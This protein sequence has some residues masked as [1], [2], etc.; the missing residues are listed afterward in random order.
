MKL[1][2]KEK[3]L[4]MNA[5][6]DSIVRVIT[7]CSYI[8]FITVAFLLFFSDVT[9][10][11]FISILLFLF[12]IDRVIH[13]KK[14]ERSIYELHG[15]EINVAK[16]F[17]PNTLRIFSYSF[18]KSIG[19]ERDFY[20]LTLLELLKR[21]EIKNILGRLDVSHKE[22]LDKVIEYT[23][24]K[25]EYVKKDELLVLCENVAVEAYKNASEIGCEFVEPYNLFAAILS[26][27]HKYISKLTNLFE[28]VPDDV[29]NAIIYARYAKKYNWFNKPPSVIGGFAY[30]TNIVRSRFMN[31][32]WTA[33]PTPMLDQ[34][35]IDLTYLAKSKKTGFLI[36]HENE[37]EL[38]INAVSRPGKPNAIL[39]GEPGS[40]KSTIISNLAFR[41]IKDKVPKVLF[42]KRLVSLNVGALL[43]NANQG[44]LTQRIQKIANDISVAGNIVLFIPIVHD[45]FKKPIDGSLAPID[46]L[47]PIIKN[48]EIPVVCETYPREFKQF[49]EQRS[50]FTEQFD[51]INV[52]EI[53]EMN[54]IKL[55]IYE[56]IILEREF[57]VF[58][59]FGAI[60]KSV[61]LAHKYFRS[62]LLPG[63]ALD[64]LKQVSAYANENKIKTVSDDIV[65]EIAE[66]Q[67]K[68]PIQKAGEN[69]VNKLLNL[70]DIIHK[71]F[72]NQKEAVSSVANAIREF[73]SGLSRSGG[74]I[75]TFLF[76]GPTGVGKTELA[77]VLAETQFGSRDLMLR[78]DMSEYQ[79]KQSVSR[80]IGS[81]DGVRGGVLTDAILK[82][83]Y[84]LILLDEFEKANSE[85][86]NLFLQ[87]F[88]DGRLTDSLNRTVD[89]QN[90]II[91]AT[92][93]AHSDFIKN[94]IEK[95]VLF[96]EIVDIIKKKL[97][98]YFKPELINRFSSVVVFRNLNEDEICAVA[99]LMLL[100]VSGV[101]KN[102]HGITV[103]FSEGAIEKIA[104]LGYS[105]VFGARPLR[106][107]ISEK[108]RS[109]FAEMIL[110]KEI[111][112]G[113]TIN[114]IFEN[115]EFKFNIVD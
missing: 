41:M 28:I 52:S 12:L 51:V 98:D 97:T 18:R 9:K 82:N 16:A 25:S 4:Y 64:L 1:L 91:I 57:N 14:G 49:I 102:T 2:F 81:V 47:L 101:L 77:K 108:V 35:G 111:A 58:I 30:K 44:D 24:T 45:L 60:K 11:K 88:D 79:D 33:R 19:T 93:N 8:F 80:L 48:N 46:L 86:L 7:Y 104:K 21:K 115:G 53:K 72:I 39:V 95:G 87:V 69:E 106:Q 13:I 78:L 54:A 110:K 34:Y 32:A 73:R 22:F 62:K 59:T 5:F 26:T 76:V 114:F 10:L 67:S 89:F 50:D 90:T 17:S 6:S 99:K 113:N 68:I 42:D 112:R 65:V 71:K 43:S 36:G 29:S 40:G 85:I 92:S 38:L 103:N 31:R 105:P 84:S 15:D 37:M 3:R 75:A 20:F 23:N 61:L 70:E 109:V 74:P 100:E 63:S 55:L 94:E 96:N 27:K 66:R 83:P 56:S 107:V